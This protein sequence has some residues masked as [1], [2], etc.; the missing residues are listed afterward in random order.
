MTKKKNDKLKLFYNDNKLDIRSSLNKTNKLNLMA[1]NLGI[2]QYPK[3][4]EC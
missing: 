3:H 2:L 1:I 4:K